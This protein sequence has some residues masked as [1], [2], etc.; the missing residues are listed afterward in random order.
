[1]YTAEQ[2]EATSSCYSKQLFTEV[3]VNTNYLWTER[4]VRTG[5]YFAWDLSSPDR[6]RRVSRFVQKIEGIIFS[7][8]DWP[9]EDE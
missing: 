5:K 7:R 6:D 2:V 1:M 9:C 4:E 3:E 8:T